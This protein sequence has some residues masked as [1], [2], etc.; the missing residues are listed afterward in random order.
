MIDPGK[1]N[2]RLT[3]ETPVESGDGQG[4]VVRSFAPQNV[5]WA[6]IAPRAAREGVTADADGAVLRITITLR[7]GVA[8]T[9]AHRLVDGARIYRIIAW[10]ER[11]HGALIEIDAELHQSPSS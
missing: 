4:G 3:L 5:V 10:R 8:L 9:R 11:D 1:L 2:T 7:G 6:Q